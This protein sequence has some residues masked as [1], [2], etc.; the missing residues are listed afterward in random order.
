MADTEPDQTIM[1]YQKYFKIVNQ[2]LTGEMT[3]AEIRK[4]EDKN[5]PHFGKTILELVKHKRM[6]EEDIENADR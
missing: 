6:L 4:W 5:L 2:Y 1:A 3:L